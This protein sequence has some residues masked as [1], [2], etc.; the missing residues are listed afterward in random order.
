MYSIRYQVYLPRGGKYPDTCIWYI[1][2]FADPERTVIGRCNPL[3]KFSRL[4]RS[5]SANALS[6]VKCIYINDEFY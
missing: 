5:K 4:C 3:S 1:Q 6:Q 2:S